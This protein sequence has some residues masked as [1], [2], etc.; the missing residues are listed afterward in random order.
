M[1]MWFYTLDG[2]TEHGPVS[3]PELKKLATGHEKLQRGGGH[4][5]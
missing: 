3:S 2:K 1:S 5:T 4:E